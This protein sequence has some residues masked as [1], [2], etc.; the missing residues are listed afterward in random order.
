L[1]VCADESQVRAALARVWNGG[2]VPVADPERLQ[3]LT[4][5]AQAGTLERVLR[6]AAG[7]E[8]T[9]AR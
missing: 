1:L 2:A 5:T 9:C 3:Q 8:A 7:M 6:R 4:W